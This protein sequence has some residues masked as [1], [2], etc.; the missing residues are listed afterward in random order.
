MATRALDMANATI[1]R[2]VRARAYATMNSME[3]PAKG[4]R[5]DITEINAKVMGLV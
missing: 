5:K 1:R 3:Q 2:K 4:V